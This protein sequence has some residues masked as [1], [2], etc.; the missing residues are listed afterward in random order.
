V[1]RP[2][3]VIGAG[4]VGGTFAAELILGGVPVTVVDRS[5]SVVAAIRR[6]GLRLIGLGG[7]RCAR[8]DRVLTPE[9]LQGPVDLAVIATR[10]RDTDSALDVLVPSL[11]SS[12]TVVSAQNGW[13]ALHIAERIGSERT[14]ACMVHMSAW[15]GEPGVYSRLEAG[16]LHLGE[17][18]G[19]PR[20]STAAVAAQLSRGIA[21]RADGNIW[22]RIW[23]KQIY[24]STF[25]INALVDVPARELYALD[26]VK[27]ILLGVI[28][29]GLQAAAAE[30]IRLEGFDRFDVAALHVRSLAD[31]PRAF[32]ALPQGSAKGNSSPYQSLKRGE[33]TGI[34]AI[35]GKLV[36]FGRRH[37]LAMSLNGEIL[38]LIGELEAG[39]RSMGWE[40]VRS[41]AAPAREYV[42]SQV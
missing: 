35:N 30:G 31:L 6:D 8:P 36:E 28:L 29:E 3:T 16:E 39:R 27:Y 4:A 40:N 38:R 2:V 11:S 14:L 22:G 15:M 42:L 9:E 10:S 25:P 13:N 37:G 21:T 26:W 7:D 20:P 24:A 32:A 41:L 18:D 17:V 19:V 1:N 23:A 12:S 33:P 34:E 5:P